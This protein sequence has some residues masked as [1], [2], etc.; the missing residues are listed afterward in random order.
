V[1]VPNSFKITYRLFRGD[2]SD[3]DPVIFYQLRS[4]M[5]HEQFNFVLDSDSLTQ[6]LF[7]LD[8]TL[9]YS[10]VKRVCDYFHI[11]EDN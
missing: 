4:Q 3:S 7:V 5:H 2:T 9:H 8:S 1:N 6:S 10:G 11:K